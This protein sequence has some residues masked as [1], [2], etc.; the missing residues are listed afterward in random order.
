MVGETRARKVR[1]GAA[2]TAQTPVQSFVQSE[3]SIP[4]VGAGD[5]TRVGYCA[6]IVL[7]CMRNEGD[8]NSVP[9]G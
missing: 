3:E 9:Q 5:R 1:F 2:N 7:V 6:G 4:A 8:R